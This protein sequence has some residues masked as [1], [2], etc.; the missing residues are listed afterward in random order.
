MKVKDQLWTLLGGQKIPED[1]KTVEFNFH[2]VEVI[3]VTKIKNL[4]MLEGAF[5][6]TEFGDF[7]VVFKDVEELD[8]DLMQKTCTFYVNIGF[9][10]E[11]TFDLHIAIGLMELRS[12]MK[13]SRNLTSGLS[14]S[15]FV[16]LANKVT[17]PKDFRDHPL[18]KYRQFLFQT[19]IEYNFRLYY[20][21]ENWLRY[22]LEEAYVGEPKS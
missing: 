17:K 21:Q 5:L 3:A 13:V 1:L 10:N 22:F 6:T 14:K 4:T 20:P 18:Q 11:G 9:Q 12:L 15:E 7:P 19:L 8:Q 2:G 16:N